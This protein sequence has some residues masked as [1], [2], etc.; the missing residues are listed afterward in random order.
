MPTPLAV[1][2]SCFCTIVPAV[3]PV[4]ARMAPFCTEP[5][6]R[7]PTVRMYPEM[8]AVMDRVVVVAMLAVTTAS[9]AARAVWIA[10]AAAEKLATA[11][12]LMVPDVFATPLM[13]TERVPLATACSSA[14][15]MDDRS[16]LRSHGATPRVL[17]GYWANSIAPGLM[18]ELLNPSK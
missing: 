11:D 17:V 4:P 15:V 10:V 16:A 5:A 9:Y 7:V 3:T 2:V 6:P 18:L 12:R 1:P 14:S 8:L 13:V